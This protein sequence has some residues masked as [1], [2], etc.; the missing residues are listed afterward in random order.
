M[1]L[2]VLGGTRFL[3]R[4]IV[5]EA[6]SRGHDVTTFSRGLSGE[7]RP[8]AE[9]LHGDRTSSADLLRL[10]EREFDAAIDTSVIAPADVAA[11]ARLLA[12]RTAHYTYVSTL[13]VYAGYPGEPVTEESAVLPGRPDAT[14][15]VESLG[16]GELKAGSEQAVQQAFPGRSLIARPGLIVGP[17]EDV[18]RLPWWLARMAAGGTV[19]APGGPGRPVRLTD[20]RDLAA[21]L[22]DNTRRGIPG[23]INVPGPEGTT[24]GG[25]LSACREVTRA[26]QA[27]PAELR[28]VPD[29]VLLAAGVEPWMELPMWLPDRPEFAG[30]WQVGG[31]R[32][33]RTGIRYRPLPDTVHDTWRWLRREPAASGGPAA[34][35][36][37]PGIGLDPAKE[38]AILGRLG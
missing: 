10:A 13:S 23:V 27:S 11:S 17:H 7:P 19:L 26:D 32:A 30:T 28:W 31:D 8:G 29:R 38:Q 12:P 14:G 24:F 16:Y 34:V 5:D 6:I 3:G 4:A 15:T 2:L 33:R 1:R 25:L 22:L 18:G 35:Q 36:R 37:R 21:W 20:A 9:A